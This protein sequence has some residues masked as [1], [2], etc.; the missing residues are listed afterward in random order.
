MVSRGKYKLPTRFEMSSLIVRTTAL[1]IMLQKLNRCYSDFAISD[2]L[3]AT[4]YNDNN[5]DKLRLLVLI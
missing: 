3:K 1:L 2:F 4:Y 5:L